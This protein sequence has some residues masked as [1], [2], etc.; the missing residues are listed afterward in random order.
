MNIPQPRPRPPPSTARSGR[1]NSAASAAPLPGRSR[2]AEATDR[3]GGSRPVPRP[4]TGSRRWPDQRIS[5]GRMTRQAARLL[6][7]R[8]PITAR[9]APKISHG[10]STSR[11]AAVNLRLL[12]LSSSVPIG[13]SQDSAAERTARETDVMT[14]WRRNW[15]GCPCGDVERIC[16]RPGLDGRTVALAG[17]RQPQLHISSNPIAP[18]L[19]TAPLAFRKPEGGLIAVTDRQ[20]ETAV[21]RAE[22][23]S[24]QGPDPASSRAACRAPQNRGRGGRPADLR[25]WVALV[26]PG[27]ADGRHGQLRGTAVPAPRERRAGDRD[28]R[29]HG[30]HRRPGGTSPRCPAGTTP[31]SSATSRW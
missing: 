27:E 5:P 21:D 17:A 2:T 29:R 25:A 20:R 24:F 30:A 4:K 26:R 1:P 15:R 19:H 3:A 31:G 12:R 10:T 6:S 9:P 13:P 23:R 14:A 18:H 7:T 16:C 28:G 8:Q 11:S 22:H